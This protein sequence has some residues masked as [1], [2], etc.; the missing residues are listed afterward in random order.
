MVLHCVKL[1]Y[2]DCWRVTIPYCLPYDSAE[3]FEDSDFWSAAKYGSSSEL[4]PLLSQDRKAGAA[5]TLGL[6]GSNQ[7][8]VHDTC[9][10]LAVWH[11]S[12]LKLDMTACYCGRAQGTSICCFRSEQSLASR[13][14]QWQHDTTRGR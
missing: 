9:S 6:K 2:V 8:S 4:L 1:L 11:I 3:G 12:V 5:V 7:R 10:I 13:W 14:L